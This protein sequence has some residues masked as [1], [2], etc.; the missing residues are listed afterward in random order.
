MHAQEHNPS[1]DFAEAKAGEPVQ[2][3]P[4]LQQARETVASAFQSIKRLFTEPKS[5]FSD[6][7]HGVKNKTAGAK[8][9]TKQGFKGLARFINDFFKSVASTF[10]HIGSSFTGMFGFGSKDTATVASEPKQE[11]KLAREEA[12]AAHLYQ[13]APQ[14]AEA[15]QV[16]QQQQPTSRALLPSAG[17]AQ[18]PQKEE[19]EKEKQDVDVGAG[20][21]PTSRAAM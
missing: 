2:K 12:K 4:L 20:V 5:L 9:K 16:N 17:I 18:T 13:L 6:L 15:L 8:D 1:P 21:K 11:E 7:Y 19:E 3:K 10:K 14:D